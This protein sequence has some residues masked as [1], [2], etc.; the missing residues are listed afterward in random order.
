[1]TDK[2]NI[3]V[4][5]GILFEESVSTNITRKI[6]ILKKD[7]IFSIN[8]FFLFVPETAAETA[9]RFERSFTELHTFCSQSNSFSVD[10]FSG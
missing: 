6:I 10:F 1:M 8:D 5:T 7:G 2:T 3:N 9:R 4:Q